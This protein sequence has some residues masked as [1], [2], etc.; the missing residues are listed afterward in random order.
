MTVGQAFILNRK[1]CPGV[2]DKP[3]FCV[4]DIYRN[5]RGFLD[6]HHFPARDLYDMPL[7]AHRNGPA[8]A[9]RR[10]THPVRSAS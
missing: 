3:M 10:G 4:K 8:C 7:D 6:K 2:P 9:H 5:Y 1:V